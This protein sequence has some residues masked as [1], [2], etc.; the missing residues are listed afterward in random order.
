MRAVI[1]VVAFL[2]ICA[3]TASSQISTERLTA[4]L[5][6]QP[7]R[8][9]F[10]L[11]SL[12]GNPYDLNYPPHF[13][14]VR[15]VLQTQGTGIDT[16]ILLRSHLQRADTV[17]YYFV[18]SRNDE[19]S[20]LVSPENQIRVFS[21]EKPFAPTRQ[22]AQLLQTALDSTTQDLAR[23]N[24]LLEQKKRSHVKAD[25]IGISVLFA[26]AAVV[27][28]FEGSGEGDGADNLMILGVGASLVSGY[29]IS[30]TI[31]KAQRLHTVKH[32]MASLEISL[33][34]KF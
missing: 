23:Y 29:T 2:T 15:L 26:V 10:W 19:F 18:P 1:L 17:I 9:L 8:V 27:S 34:A 16:T 30:Q 25:D 22:D 32:E 28:F 12:S 13:R 24:A 31:R 7:N 14:S 5:R 6:N 4:Y 11:D 3:G 33:N 21:N 20:D